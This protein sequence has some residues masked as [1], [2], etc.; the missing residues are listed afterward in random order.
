[1]QLS[2]TYILSLVDD[3]LCTVEQKEMRNM[4]RHLEEGKR[5]EASLDEL[6]QDS[7]ESDATGER[8]RLKDLMARLQV[9][10]TMSF[11]ICSTSV[12]VLL[13]Q[14]CLSDLSKEIILSFTLYQIVDSKCHL[15]GCSQQMLAKMYIHIW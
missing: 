13:A 7:P 5:L 15:H 3:V 2:L 4:D 6:L 10:E 11:H 1:M 12:T 8:R 14:I 9:R